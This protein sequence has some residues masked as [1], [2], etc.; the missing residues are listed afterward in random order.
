MTGKTR[1]R[2]GSRQKAIDQMCRLC[3]YDPQGGLG[4]WR[5]QVTMCSAFDCPLWMFRPVSSEPLPD[6]AVAVVLAHHEISP[7]DWHR[8]VANFYTRPEWRL[9]EAAK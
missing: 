2:A 9:K 5:Q 1:R 4:T 7:T 3:L 8:D 6:S